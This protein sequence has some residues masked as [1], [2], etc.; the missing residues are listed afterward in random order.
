TNKLLMRFLSTIFLF[1]S[2]FFQSFS[3]HDITLKGSISNLGDSIEYIHLSSFNGFQ[4]HKLDNNTF[5]FKITGELPQDKVNH[6]F[7]VLS[8]NEYKDSD[9][10]VAALNERKELHM[11]KDPI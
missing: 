5:E 4:V 2:I 6:A 9:S 10:L 8:K 11:G 3:A 7:I 1:V